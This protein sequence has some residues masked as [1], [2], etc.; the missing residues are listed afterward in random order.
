M[1]KATLLLVMMLLAT[2]LVFTACGGGSEEPAEEPAV[3][4]EAGGEDAAEGDA[5]TQA[6]E[7][8]FS[9]ASVPTIDPQRFNA[10]PSYVVMKGLGEGLIRTHE[11]EVMPGVAESWVVSEDNMQMTFTLRQDATFSD[12]SPIT[13]ND[14]VYAFK[15]LAD[16]DDPKDYSWVLYEI[17][18]FA[19]IAGGEMTVDDLGVSAPDDYTFVIDFAS[20]APYYLSFL[21]MPTFYPQKQELVEQYGDQYALSAEAF[22]G[23][24]PY[25][26]VEYSLEDI[27]VMEK[28]ENYWNADAVKLDKVTIRIMEQQAAF[29]LFETGELDMAD[30][31]I[32]L[33]ASYVDG[34]ST[35][36]EGSHLESFMSGALDWFSVNIAS[37]DNPIL[38]NKDFRLALNYALDRE[39]FIAISSGNIYSPHTRFVL[40]AVAGENGFYNDEYPIEVYQTTAELDKA[41]EHLQAA[42]D[43]MGITDPSEISFSITIADNTTRTIA[44]NAQDQWMRN[45]GI[46]VEVEIVTYPAML[47]NRVD[48]IFDLI[49]A[50]WMPDYNDPYTYLSYFVSTNAQN[51]GGFSNER[52]DELVNTANTFPDAGTRLSMYAEAEQILLE[53]AGIIPLHVREVPYAISDDLH[54]FV[55]FYLGSES[56]YTYAYFE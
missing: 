12:G 15:R 10:S 43:A 34:S 8:T 48:G 22:L 55:R 54:D 1:K 13:A 47:S 49:Y 5:A 38:G 36:P 26:L 50:G 6:Q 25:K 37:E 35:L 30:I 7:L 42:M 31:P 33:A 17:K 45:L 44:E 41:Q 40:P 21:D 18:N 32:A 16:Q 46:N 56:D 20:P 29:A 19:E 52:Y 39:E 23:N 4:E 28:N 51:G 53:E 9:L 11:G 27:I 3:G 24:G 14:F 2:M